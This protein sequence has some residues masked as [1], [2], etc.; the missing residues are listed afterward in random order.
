[1]YQL[2]EIISSFNNRFE[3]YFYLFD[4]HADGSDSDSAQ[5]NALRIAKQYIFI[6]LKKRVFYEALT[7][8]E[9]D[10]RAD[11]I[12]DKVKAIQAKSSEA[13]DAN[14]VLSHFSQISKGLAKASNKSLRH[15]S[16]MFKFGYKGEAVQDDQIQY[17]LLLNIVCEE[18]ESSFLNLLVPTQN[19]V[20]NVGPNRDAWH[21]NPSSNTLLDS[22][23]Y[24]TFG[25]LIGSILRTK[26]SINLS[27][28]LLFFKH[29]LFENVSAED[30]KEIDFTTY[31]LLQKL[32]NPE[33]HGITPDTF[34]TLV[35]EKFVIRYK[36][37]QVELC[38]DGANID[39]TY[40]NAVT[41][42]D[43]LEKHKLFENSNAYDYIRK[44]ISAVIPIDRL[45][46]FTGLQF[47]Q[48]LLGVPKINIQVLK[49]NTDYEN[50][51][52]TDAHI[53]SF[54]ET[55]EAFNDQDKSIF[56][57]LITE[58]ARLTSWKLPNKFIIA[59]HSKTG[60]V[61]TFI[62]I[63]DETRTR[64]ELPAYSNKDIMKEKLVYT[65]THR[66]SSE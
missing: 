4:T 1:M 40:D 15:N 13:V 51:I 22:N 3:T 35:T 50:C 16:R 36:N 60:A 33:A 24:L 34:S 37:H 6:Q 46:L 41:Y 63:F 28:P 14:G 62:P 65:I 7:K 17:D 10:C 8:T 23:L 27:L 29:L 58:R 32:R 30:L 56:V 9:S 55:I 59:K 18:L 20:L 64:L 31:N 47:K 48:L 57:N 39:V 52:S 26:K 11:I 45:N 49:E 2:K 61:N 21:I 53:I 19:N 25:K 66:Q 42:A 12:I 54:W 5:L 43:L 44:G 38:E